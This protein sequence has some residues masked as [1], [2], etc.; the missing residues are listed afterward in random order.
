MPFKP[1]RTS[2][3][4]AFPASSFK[5]G[6]LEHLRNLFVAFVQG[7]FEAAPRGAYHWDPSEDL[8]EIIIRDENPIHVTNYGERPCVNFTRG[9][10]QFFGLGMGDVFDWRQ[11]TGKVTKAV[12]LP[13]TMS[14]NCSSRNDIESERIAFII[15]EHIWLL[16]EQ[17]MAQGMFD[18]G[19]PTIGAPSRGGE[20]IAS[21]SADEWYVTSANF[22]FQLYR[23]SQF[24]PLGRTVVE[25]ISLRM[26]AVAPPQPDKGPLASGG[27]ELPYGVVEHAP[28]LVP[29]TL[30][31]VRVPLEN[32]PAKTVVVTASFPFRP[33]IRGLQVAGRALPFPGSSVEE[34]AVP[35]TTEVRPIKV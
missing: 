25:N 29:S 32:N 24:T 35:R 21:D 7:L 16:R 4:G 3:N 31:E 26:R 6:P 15:S 30:D 18:I 28:V 11:D 12:L 9:P 8:S 14:I 23:T 22:P 13:G 17:L 5:Y 1:T 34:S 19:R 27:H 10:M 2:D 20:V 33:G